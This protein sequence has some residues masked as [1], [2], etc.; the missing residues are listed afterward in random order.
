LPALSAL[1]AL[2]AL[3]TLSRLLH[4]VTRDNKYG[5]LDKEPSVSLHLLSTASYFGDK[6]DLARHSKELS[7][8]NRQ[9]F[10]P[11][12]TIDTEIVRSVRWRRQYEISIDRL[13]RA[14]NSGKDTF[15]VDVFA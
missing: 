14:S 9:L 8:Y 2:L 7:F 13:I 1:S 6:A 12:L 15:G 3:S 4:P 10:E 5:N 11:H